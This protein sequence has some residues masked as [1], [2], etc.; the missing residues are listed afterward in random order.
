MTKIS[1]LRDCKGLV[2]LG[3]FLGMLRKAG[4]TQ[5]RYSVPEELDKGFFVGSISKDLGLEPC[6][7]AGPGVRIVSRGGAQLFA[8]N[9]RSGSLVTAGRIDREELYAGSTECQLNL[10]VLVE[11]KGKIYGVEVEVRDINDH[12]PSFRES[13][14]EIKT[15]ESAATGMRFPLPHAWD[16]DVGKDA[17]Q[18]Y[19]LSPNVHFSLEAR[20]GAEGSRY[21]ELVL[22][23]ALDR[24]EAA[25]HPLV[26]TAFDAGA[27]ARSGTTRVRVTLV[28]ANDSAPEFARS[29]YRASV[30]ENVAAG[31]RLLR[32]HAADPDQGAN[33]PDVAITFL[34]SSVLENAPRRTLIAL[35]DVKDRDSGGGGTDGS[36][37]PSGRVCPLD[38]RDLTGATTA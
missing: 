20:N 26:L 1:V 7:L 32:I 37:A 15:S 16:P 24:E 8:L 23:R 33:A 9:S 30:L 22:E 21:P 29:E 17:L 3:V 36:S 2:F 18:S 13:E 11:D 28:D 38:W 6:E 31:A 35:L 5:I 34:F 27:P 19:R 10:E 12:A 4:S 14:L 25:A